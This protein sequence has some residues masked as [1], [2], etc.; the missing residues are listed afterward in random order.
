MF[1]HKNIYQQTWVSNNH[2]TRNQ[3]DHITV[4]AGHGSNVMDVR[5]LRGIYSDTDH[6][7]KREERRKREKTLQIPSKRKTGR[8]AQRRNV[9]YCQLKNLP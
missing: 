2:V 3:I 7:L 8:T 1:L 6:Y 4:D 9:H 5:I